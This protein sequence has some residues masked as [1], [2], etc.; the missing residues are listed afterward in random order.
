MKALAVVRWLLLVS[1]LAHIPFCIARAEPPVVTDSPAWNDVMALPVPSGEPLPFYAAD[2]LQAWGRA[3]DAHVL[4]GALLMM[5]LRLADGQTLPTGWRV[6]D[7]WQQAGGHAVTDAELNAAW[8]LARARSPAATSGVA[9][10]SGP[11][12]SDAISVRELANRVAGRPPVMLQ[13]FLERNADCQR[14]G[15]CP[16]A[17]RAEPLE[18]KSKAQVPDGERAARQ[19]DRRERRSMESFAAFAPIVY[20]LVGVGLH[21]LIT[22]LA[23]G[24]TAWMF[25]LAQ[26]PAMAYAYMRI[27]GAIDNYGSLIIVMFLAFSGVYIGGL[28]R[29]AYRRWFA[30]L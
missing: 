23:G 29:V 13:A 19:Q 27:G 17:Q 1:V 20:L 12:R 7:V 26:G 25:S 6:A 16:P 15:T 18:A 28:G 10:W 9:S 24:V 21:V 3:G 14:Q 5:Q 22:R 2:V 8:Q 30:S 4:R 11:L